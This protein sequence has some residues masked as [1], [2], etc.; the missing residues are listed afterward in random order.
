MIATLIALAA[1]TAPPLALRVEV[2]ELPVKVLDGKGKLVTGLPHGSFRVF[3][4]V[5]QAVA[6]F[7]SHLLRAGNRCFLTT[8]SFE[9]KMQVEWNGDP[10][11]LAGALGR[12]TPQGG[13]SLY[14]AVVRAL[15]QFRGH[16]AM[17]RVPCPMRS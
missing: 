15:E 10:Q 11:G 5:R 1:A 16:R 12:V 9:P 2:V 13:T 14:D 8:F 4:D 7:A 6:G 3:A 17:I